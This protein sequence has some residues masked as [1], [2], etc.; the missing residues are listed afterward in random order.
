M[1]LL[2]CALVLITWLASAQTGHYFL[3]HF[4]STDERIDYLNFDIVQADNG[5]LYFANKSGIVEFDGRNWSI[6]ES[7]GAIYTLC[8]KNQDVYAGGLTGFGKLVLDEENNWNFKRL[9][10]S[11]P[12]AKNIIAS[13]ATDSGVFFANE[14]AIYHYQFETDSITRI[15][16]E[17]HQFTGLYRIRQAIYASI[18]TGLLLKIEKDK[19]FPSDLNFI[20]DEELLFTDNQGSKSNVLIATTTDKL[21]VFDGNQATPINPEDAEYIGSNIMIGGCWVNEDLIAIGTLRGGVIFLNPHTGTT[22]QITNYYTG[23][24]DNEVFA[25]LAD[26]N[27]GIWVAHDYGFTRIAPYMPFR[28]FNYYPGLTGNLLS[29][30]SVGN[31]VYVGTSVGLFRLT[32]EEVYG[33]EIYYVTRRLTQAT[34]GGADAKEDAAEVEREKSRKG[35]FSF[36]RKR[37]KDD[38]P[39]QPEPKETPATKRAVTRTVKEKRTRRVLRSL[40]YAYK[41]V[42]NIKGKVTQLSV[43]NGRLLAA[44]IGGMYEIDSISSTM[45]AQDPVRTFSFS[46]SLDQ[47][48][49]STYDDRI[50][51][52]TREEGWHETHLMDTIREFVGNIFEDRIQNIWLCGRAAIIK[53]ESVD[54]E[55][56]Q[57]SKVPFETLVLDETTGFA[58]GNDVYVAASG[59]FHRFDPVNERFVKYDSLPG[60]RKY[61]TS[62]GIFWF[63]D[64]HHWRTASSRL[65]S[66]L[67]LQWLALFPEVRYLT[68]TGDQSGLWLI[69]SGNELFR[70]DAREL[71]AE[72]IQYP[73]LL[74]EVI[75]TNRKLAPGLFLK[76]SELQSHLTL[77]FVQPDYKGNQSVE[78]QY[79]VDGLTN[80][81]SAWSRD[82][83]VNF[84]YL[85]AGRYTLQVKARNLLGEES[86]MQ[87]IVFSVSPPYWQQ[88][89]FYALEF[90]FFGSLVLLT[91]RL[92][93]ANSKYRYLSRLL[94]VLTVIMLIQF[95]QT[96][97]ESLFEA[98]TPVI[99]FFVQVV[100]ALLVL[101]LESVLRKFMTL[102][103]EGKYDL[104]NISTGTKDEA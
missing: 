8:V 85:P 56:T 55:I 38:E 80:E 17:G 16:V 13:E 47:L 45:I 19:A 88:T 10:A 37:K 4:T 97:A 9:S 94:S 5:I 86:A 29:A 95:V 1:R 99:G 54:G 39:E 90:I 24:P 83:E 100:I 46:S 64:G 70:F 58:L 104:K 63:N 11:H 101:P 84:N 67:N 25:M 60:P 50:R 33:E 81:W 78:Y 61:F 57:V 12:D 6:I 2:C 75:G 102:A 49:V 68:L 31:S 27:Q 91:V 72:N 44:G 73:L 62:D 69:T 89:W 18:E 98:E 43:V 76:V 52:F 42:E 82:N 30:A 87:P 92:S 34:S 26:R 51:T 20:L 53:V 23:L 21:F 22:E 3:T 7:P 32:K 71:T 77:K 35:L 48:V 59:A 79:F 36:L 28:P 103:S 14:S 40:E 93:A 66:N 15:Q 96:A 74:K 41:P 65:H